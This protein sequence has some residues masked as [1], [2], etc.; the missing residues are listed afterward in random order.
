MIFTLKGE[1]H[2]DGMLTHMWV[3]FFTWYTTNFMYDIYLFSCEIC[4]T[5]TNLWWKRGEGDFT[6]NVFF[7]R[8]GVMNWGDFPNIAFV[9]ICQ[10][11]NV[12]KV[13]CNWLVC[14]AYIC[15]TFSH[16]ISLNSCLSSIL[17]HMKICYSVNNVLIKIGV[18][19]ISCETC[20]WR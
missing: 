2:L 11:G 20:Y 8:N 18:N 5:G 6:R 13:E 19:V 9:F 1:I 10:G 4:V 16:D 7:E 15:L 3:D 12:G 17:F 14:V